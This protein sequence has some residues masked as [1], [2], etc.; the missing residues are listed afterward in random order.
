MT[1]DRVPVPG[2]RRSYWLV[3]ALAADAGASCPPLLAETTAD[4]CVVGG[5]FAGLWTALELV[6]REPSLDVVVLEQDICGG[7][8]SGR[9]AGLFS[10]SWHHLDDLCSVYGEDPG[11]EYATLIAREVSDTQVWC[12]EHQVDAWFRNDG[13]AYVSTTIPERS[14]QLVDGAARRGVGD[15]LELLDA[16][17]VRALTG[18]PRFVSAALA[19]DGAT[20]QP[21]RLARGLRRVA[22]DAGIRIYEQS[23][24]VDVAYDSPA[25]VRTATGSVRAEQA[26]LT[27]GAWAAG[28]RRY[29]RAVSNLTNYLVVTEPLGDRLGEAGWRGDTGIVG[30]PKLIHFARKT[31]DGR[32]AIGGTAAGVLYGARLGP[33]AFADRRL[34]EAAAT[35]LA[36][37]FPTLRGVRFDYAWGGPLDMTPTD[38]PFFETLAPGNIH[39]GIGFSGHGLS[40]T[41]LGAKTLAS[42]VLGTPDPYTT[43][44]VVG[45]MIARTPPEP[46]RWPVVRSVVWA[47]E[48]GDA[49]ERRGKPRGRIRTLI[50]EAPVIYRR[51]LRRRR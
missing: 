49:A 13:I 19:R 36:W 47:L 38:S 5:G 39:T 12:R 3:E 20:V 26:V 51:R 46:L 30:G 8:A 2:A 9:N 50:G 27:V 18:S 11:I 22:L 14:R 24:V 4:V 37:L 40:A 23:R 1:V 17:Q 31:A 32:V 29:R 21:G 25:V 7:G 28:W 42:L 35:S 41:R 43:L 33:K 34:A 10:A 16:E 15:R 45:P 44:P 6:R 48:H